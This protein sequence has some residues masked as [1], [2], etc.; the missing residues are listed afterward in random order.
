MRRTL[1]AAAA[2][3]ALFAVPSIAVA[4]SDTG[5]AHSKVV[6]A[7]QCVA[8]K[9]ADRAAFGASY[10]KHATRNCIKGTTDEVTEATENAAQRCRTERDA[11][12]AAFQATYGSN[13]P[14]EGSRGTGRNAFGKCVSSGVKEE[15]A[16]DVED[17]SNAA[18]ECRT[19][20]GADPAAF[21]EAWGTN[22]PAGENSHGTKKNAFGKCVS[23]T[24][25][26]EEEGEE[27]TS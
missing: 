6:A 11:D 12:P 5:E 20:R 3:T 18:D 15:L 8:L 19:A 26:D 14:S 10:G 24:A 21:M 27:A 13:E 25:E 17:F 4:G 1:I 9:K 16:E 23:A 7:K 22:E 2:C